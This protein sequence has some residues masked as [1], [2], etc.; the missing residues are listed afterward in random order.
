MVSAPVAAQQQLPTNQTVKG[1]YWVRYLG[2]NDAL[3]DVAESFSGA[4]TFDGNGGLSV[5]GTGV[6]YSNGSA[7]P[8]QA[9]TSGSYNVLPSGAIS[10]SNPFDSSGSKSVVF[11]GVG[12]G[13]VIIGSSS[14]YPVLDLFVAIPQATNASTTTLN[15]SYYVAGMEFASGSLSGMRNVFFNMNANGSGSLGNVAVNGFSQALSDKNTSQTLPGAT[16]TLSGNGSGTLVLPAPSGVTAANQLL[17]GTKTLYVSQDGSFF[18]SGSPTGF[19]MQIGVKALTGSVSTALNGEFF[20]GTL[21]NYTSGSND[22]SPPV[23]SYAGATNEVTSAQVELVHSRVNGAGYVVLGSQFYDNDYDWTY[24]DNF[25][26]NSDG[27]SSGSGYMFALGAGGNYAVQIGGPGDY[28]LTAWAK[29]PSYS[30]TGVFINPTGVVNALSSIPF[31]AQLSPG[32][33]IS[34]YGT[35]LAS[36]TDSPSS[37]PFPTNFDGV[38]VMIGGT[39]AP[40]TVVSPTQI[41]AIVPYSVTADSSGMVSIQVINNGAQSNVVKE[42][43]GVTSPGI[44][45]VPTGGV[46]YAAMLHQ[47]GVTLVTESNPAKVGEIVS[48]Y[49][50]GLGA[51]NPAVKEGS[52]S[53]SNPLSNTVNAAAVYIDDGANYPQATVSYQGLAPGLASGVNQINFKVPSGLA[54]SGAVTDFTIEISTADAD[55]MQALIPV[56]NSP[57]SSQQ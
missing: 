53:P 19:D 32:E 49:L 36:K 37:L 43:L 47:D 45:T 41:N 46:G 15:G 21:E 54:F 18:I 20:T 55:N 31:T 6:I 50:T 26:P 23:F 52:Q 24:D 48:I 2:V 33:I 12:A 34:I 1:S 28:L 22:N 9:A 38:Q 16:Y 35:G 44:A 40:I 17:S 14:D 8:L 5:T 7:A 30:G 11:G 51:V 39:A 42:F 29:I 27:T 13:G 3:G 10:L 57:N 25:T 56:A 4:I